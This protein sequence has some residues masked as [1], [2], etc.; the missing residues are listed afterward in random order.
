MNHITTLEAYCRN[1]NIPSP[2]SPLYDIRRFEDNMRTVKARVE[3][4]RHQ[5][6]AVALRVDGDGYTK[7]G[8]FEKEHKAAYT[9]FFNSPYQEVWWDIVPNWTGYYILVTDEFMEQYL[10]QL[11]MLNDYP[12][13][14]I[15]QTVPMQ[16]SAEEAEPMLYAFDRIFEEYYGN[17]KDSFRLISPHT[18]LLLEHTRRCF[19]KYAAGAEG[20]TE[21]NR[22]ADVLLVSRLKVLIES[23]LTADDPPFHPHAATLYAEA[24]H[25]H[26]NYLNAVVKRTIGKTLKA[27]IQDQVIYQAKALLSA[28]SLSNKEISY[29]LHFEEPTHFNALFKKLTQ[30]TP[31][32]YRAS[33]KEA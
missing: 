26:P 6:Y 32:Q 19:E 14:R 4:F 25:V 7:T 30:L 8:Q 3:P 2:R 29:R 10:P 24:L 13:F 15:D 18:R 23:S 21:K 31:G 1:I 11:S 12:F 5:F 33:L 28:S 22:N 20:L 27:L 16:L 9:L 17:R